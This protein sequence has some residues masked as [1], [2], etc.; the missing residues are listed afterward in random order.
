MLVIVPMMAVTATVR[1][2]LGLSETRVIQGRLS[3]TE[4]RVIEGRLP[5]A[6]L[7]EGRASE[8]GAKGRA[9]RGGVRRPAEG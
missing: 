3:E 8:W 9:K 7:P 4:T 2:H 1:S 5:K 6:G